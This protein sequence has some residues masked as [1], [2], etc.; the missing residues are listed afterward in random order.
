MPQFLII[1]GPNGAGKSTFSAIFS[2]PQAL[3]FDPDKERRKI[4]LQYPDISQDAVES[5]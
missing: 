4:E 3:I 2:R 5:A 1:A